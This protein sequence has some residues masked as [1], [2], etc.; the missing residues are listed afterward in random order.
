MPSLVTAADNS[1]L[2]APV[3]LQEV[4]DAVFQLDA[5]SAPGPDGFS[6]HF[7][8]S[9]WHIVADDCLDWPTVS[10]QSGISSLVRVYTL[11]EPVVAFTA[12]ERSVLV[13]R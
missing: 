13:E 11:N 8:R 3:Q 2:L 9:A 1:T 5:A 12:E 7:F 4:K 6:G 10:V